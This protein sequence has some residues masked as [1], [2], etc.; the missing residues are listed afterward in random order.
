MSNYPVSLNWV[1]HKS[2]FSIPIIYDDSVSLIDEFNAFLFQ[3][4]IDKINDAPS[5]TAYKSEINLYAYTLKSFAAFLSK[6]NLDWKSCNDDILR[7]FR[8]WLYQ[9]TLSDIKSM[10]KE[11]TAKRT[12][13]VKIRAL[14]RFYTWAQ[15]SMHYISGVVGLGKKFPINSILPR[16]ETGH[17]VKRYD[18]R[19]YPICYRKC[20]EGSKKRFQYSA[21]NDDKVKLTKYFSSSSK[22]TY[23]IE[24][25]ILVMELASQVGWRNGSIASLNIDDFSDDAI[26]N[27]GADGV[28]VTPAIQ[29]LGYEKT[30]LVP[31]SLAVRIN[32]HIKNERKIML[33]HRGIRQSQATKQLF[34]NSKNG[35][36]VTETTF[37]QLFSKAFKKIGCPTRSGIHSF[38]RKFAQDETDKQYATRKKEGLSLAIEDTLLPVADKLGQESLTSQQTYLVSSNKHCDASLEA[39][40]QRENYKMSVEL[41]DAHIE[42]E[43][44]K[45]LLD[46]K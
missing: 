5:V 44:L 42:I 20:G 35:N 28:P 2:G 7:D 1:E 32:K 41:M 30:F 29:K 6:K 19:L 27:A 36:P 25:N 31:I 34:L 26:N 8:G 15:N 46:N 22:S 45:K 12:T 33:Q 24:R 37:V 43:R 18:K 23:I 10:R 13:N 17:K 14:Y 38:R 40:L 9:S 39:E 11:N 4:S 16:K 21:T 3:L